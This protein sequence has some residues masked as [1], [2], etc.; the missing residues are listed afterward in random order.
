MHG[1]DDDED[2]IGKGGIVYPVDQYSMLTKSILTYLTSTH[3]YIDILIT[4]PGSPQPP[5]PPQRPHRTDH[6]L[7][8]SD[9]PSSAESRTVTFPVRPLLFPS[10]KLTI[11]HTTHQ[12]T[13]K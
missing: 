1:N 9:P 2:G 10:S 5:Q 4:I 12:Q 7:H 13:T 6:Q 8:L 3:T 11:R